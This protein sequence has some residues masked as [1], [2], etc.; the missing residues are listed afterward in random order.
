MQPNYIVG[1]GEALW[2]LLPTGPQLGGAPANFAYHC[3]QFKL[4]AIAVSALGNDRLAEETLAQFQEKELQYI[5]P[6]VSY[7]TGTVEVSIDAQGIPAYEIKEDVAWDHIPFTT[8]IQSLAKNCRAVCWGSLA[9]RNP[10]S[11]HTIESFLSLT[12]DSCIRIFDINLRQH[13]Y[14]LERIESSLKLCNILKINDEELIVLR[15]LLAYSEEGENAFCNY[16][17]DQY[18][19][20][21]LVLTCGSVGSH[22]FC[23]DK[24]HSYIPTPMVKVVDTVGAGDSFTATFC[25]AL[26]HNKP[27]AEAHRLAVE[28]SAYICT[29]RG[30]MPA[31]PKS[32]IEQIEM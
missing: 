17:I 10:D 5:M 19:L 28:V 3:A 26:L 21:M 20:E 30:A 23:R 6:R 9:Q 4:P 1:L 8:E 24:Q 2:D 29:C 31:L 18:Q 16:L 11:R 25:A 12:P 27:I 15:R 22:V 14:T 32:Y 7:P 13:Y